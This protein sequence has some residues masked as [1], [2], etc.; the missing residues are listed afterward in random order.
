MPPGGLFGSGEWKVSTEAFPLQPKHV[1]YLKK[2]GPWLR[3]FQE[4]SDLLYKQS[5]TGKAPAY[6]ADWIDRGKP[7]DLKSISHQTANN[8][9]LPSLL[10]PDLLLT[11]DGFQLTEIDSLPGGSGVMAWMNETYSEFEE[12]VIGTTEAASQ[13][14]GRFAGHDIVISEE[15]FSYAPEFKWLYGE[16][17]VKKAEHYQFNGAPVY[18]FFEGF[19]WPSMRSLRQ[20]WSDQVVMDAP[21]KVHLEE[22]LW[23]ALFW[24]QP[25]R[26]FWKQ[27][28]GG[29]YDQELQKLIPYTWPLEPI[30]L[31]PH[32]VIPKLGIHQW[33][34]AYGFSKAERD[35][36]IKLS[37]F[38]PLA[39]G[40]KSVVM[41]SDVPVA[42][43]EETLKMALRHSQD[44]LWIMQE[45][46]KAERATHSLYDPVKNSRLDVPVRARICPFYLTSA[47]KTE[48]I[49][50]HVTLCPPDKK[51]IHG[52]QDAIIVPAKELS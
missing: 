31:P 44:G 16:A 47:E 6:I 15:A 41:G 38:S 10:R 40:S 11:D 3:K 21:L 24:M 36:V 37:G 9:Q 18:R 32:G 23:M 14:R 20:S 1:S 4:A 22:K 7:E 46:K 34:D 43:W 12:G 30:D 19:D 48:L 50:V 13:L 42:E 28:L 39:W 33:E 27:Q 26:E 8:G 51:K 5:L 29:R 17:Q 49:G 52:M 35:L 45:F 2:L 25:L